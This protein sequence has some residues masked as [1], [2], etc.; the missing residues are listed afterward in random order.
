MEW[1]RIKTIVLIILAVA[2]VGLLGM[3]VQRDLQ[4]QSAQREAREN[5]LL[6]LQENGISL[7]EGVL[8]QEMELL[9]A[10]AKLTEQQLAEA[11]TQQ[12]QSACST[13]STNTTETPPQPPPTTTHAWDWRSV[14]LGAMAGL[15]IATV[16][17]VLMRTH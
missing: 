15:A 10:H 5:V 17:Q 14:A 11:T 1:S 7:E 6:F 13:T 16:A 3:L 2:N 9:E 8:P 12:Q 4:E